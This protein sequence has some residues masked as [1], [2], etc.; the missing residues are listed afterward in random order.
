MSTITV[1]VRGPVGSG[2]SAVLGEIEIALRALGL[3]VV[4]ADPEAALSEKR[5]TH[6]DWAS[7]L[8]MYAPEIT[9]V[10]EIAS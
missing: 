7:A 2:K 5:M 1:I 4:F 9:L 3:T 10:E 8:E 6:A